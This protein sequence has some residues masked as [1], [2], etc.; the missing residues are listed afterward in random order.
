[1]KADDQPG[2][3]G[4]ESEMVFDKARQH[5]QRET[6]G[7]IAEEGENDYREDT[8]IELAVAQYSDIRHSR[9]VR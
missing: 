3:K 4:T 8:F 1:L 6:N 9:L 7:E 2:D 5:G